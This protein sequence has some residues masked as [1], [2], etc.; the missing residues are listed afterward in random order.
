MLD[1]YYAHAVAWCVALRRVSLDWGPTCLITA[2][3]MLLRGVFACRCARVSARVPS[4]G[5]NMSDHRFARVVAPRVGFE[6]CV[7]VSAHVP[8]LVDHCS[9]CAAAPSDGV[10]ALCVSARVSLAWGL[11][12]VITATR[13]LSRRVLASR[14]ACVSARISSLGCSMLDHCHMHAVAWRICL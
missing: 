14:R 8:I 2:T 7:R 1:H 10:E 11:T 13:V 12:C 3:C 5:S 4:L 6:A 9:A